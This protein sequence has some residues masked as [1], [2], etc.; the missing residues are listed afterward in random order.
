M[1]WNL[2]DETRKPLGSI[3]LSRT[4]VR[5]ETMNLRTV[6][7]MLGS[8]A[9]SL[10]LLGGSD[11]VA[12][13]WLTKETKLT[14]SD[15]LSLDALGFSTGISGDTVIVGSFPPLHG[16]TNPGSAYVFV[17]EGIAWIQQQ[18]LRPAGIQ[19]SD[20]LGISVAI[21]GDTA[22]IGAPGSSPDPG[23]AY[24]F[25]RSGNAWSLQQ[26][27]TSPTPVGANDFGGFG[28][29]VALAGD[30]ALIGDI[31]EGSVGAAYVFV[32]SGQTWGVQQ[33]LAVS[34]LTVGDQFGRQAAISGGTAV[35]G[36]AGPE[37]AYVFVRTGGVWTEQQKLTTGAPGGS[38]IAGNSLS[39]DGDTIVVGA[40]NTRDSA[41][42]AFVFVRSG[43]TWSLQQELTAGDS[44]PSALFGESAAVKGDKVVVGAPNAMSGEGAAY[45]FQRRGRV[46][47]QQQEIGANDFF[48]ATGFGSAVAVGNDAAVVGSPHFSAGAAYVY[49]QQLTSL[50]PAKVWVGLRNSDDAGIRFD[51][52]AK[53]YWNGFSVG[54][55][56]LDGVLGGSSGFANARLNAIPL[57][58]T[59]PIDAASGDTLAMEVLV[60]NGCSGSSHGSGTARLW[61]NGQPMDSGAARDAGTRFGATI[62]GEDSD[63]FLRGG[64][65]L[66][67]A[68]GN[69]RLSVDAPVGARCG[70]FVS[71][72]RWMMTRP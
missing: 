12:G 39:V 14:A 65:S 10:A 61:Y 55:G 32:R 69:S 4:G 45:V 26:K 57:T 51:L 68:A 28:M 66:S 17:R 42:S 3:S 7:R 30:T 15:G 43:E 70:S 54:S 53:V 63:E 18:K 33:R 2:P 64:F 16:G 1:Q 31:G 62:G 52:M 48:A 40:L 25:V 9:L 49:E 11:A 47:S 27:L 46:W 58:L 41:G 44:A 20:N 34:G 72:G 60:R 38:T 24:V 59:S 8:V 71:F 22:I 56:E 67:A 36:I 37:E 6:S 5:R 19:A 21:D 13:P 35:V 29:S 23:A 50:S